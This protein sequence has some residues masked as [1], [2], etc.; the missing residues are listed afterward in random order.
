[1]K[2]VRA[3]LR[4][5]AQALTNFGR[6]QCST[7]AAAISYFALF[8]LFPMLLFVI[9]LL[10]FFVHGADQRTR[11]VDALVAVVGQGIERSAISAQVDA[12]AGGRGDLG[13][14]GLAVAVWS[15]SAVFG[16]VRKGLDA[17]WKVTRPR[18][19]VSTKLRDLGMVLLSGLF[20]LFALAITGLCAAVEGFGPQLLGNRVGPITHMLSLAAP[21]VVS[22][23]GVAL[24]YYFVPDA[25]VR[26]RDVWLGALIAALLFQVAQAGFGIY[27]ANFAHYDRLYG[28]LGAVIAVLFYVYIGANILLFGGEITKAYADVRVRRRV[29]PAKPSYPRGNRRES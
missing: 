19:M 29:S 4:L 27:V 22:F 23:S 3:Y 18:P 1:V 2:T 8:S 10:G 26:L 12:F 15:A 28:S 16:A 24:L 21:A 9:S 5:F 20:M 7:F 17:A 25:K 6:D 14:I 13:A 11:I